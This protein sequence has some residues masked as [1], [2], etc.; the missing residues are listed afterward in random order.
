MERSKE[1]DT[2][3]INVSARNQRKA[4]GTLGRLLTTSQNFICG[5]FICWKTRKSWTEYQ[6]RRHD[7]VWC[8]SN[9]WSPNHWLRCSHNPEPKK[10][11]IHHKLWTKKNADSPQA[12]HELQRA[13]THPTCQKMMLPSEPPLAN[14]SSCTGCQATEKASFLWPRKTWRSVRIAFAASVMESA[15]LSRQSQRANVKKRTKQC[16]YATNDKCSRLFL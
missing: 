5:Q 15:I 3:E 7:L 8:S 14:M 12:V 9:G 2:I 6:G 10:T 4:I 13:M 16:G 1:R 11:L